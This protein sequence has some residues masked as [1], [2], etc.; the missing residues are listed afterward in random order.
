M[1]TKIITET[2]F[3]ILYVANGVL[4]QDCYPT[5]DAAMNAGIREESNGHTVIDI[6]EGKLDGKVY[7]RMAKDGGW[8]FGR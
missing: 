3:S 1:A 8:I 5:E 6:I 4:F 2:I 7:R